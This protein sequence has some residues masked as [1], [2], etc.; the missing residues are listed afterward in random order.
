MK[1]RINDLIK[2]LSLTKREFAREISV[3][4]EG[5]YSQLSG[6]RKIT[7]RLIALICTR[8]NVRREWL[9]NG[10][11]SMFNDSKEESETDVIKKHAISIYNR[12]PD[13]LKLLAI[14]VAKSILSS[15]ESHHKRGESKNVQIGDNN[16]NI[17]IQQ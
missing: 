15:A 10:V 4:E 12:L 16:S 8:F 9:E 3:N 14:E 2:Y 7:P 17:N 1:D 11:G 13:D 5:F 6:K